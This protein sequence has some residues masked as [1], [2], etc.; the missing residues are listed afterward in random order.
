MNYCVTVFGCKKY[1]DVAH[2]FVKETISLNEE[3]ISSSVFFSDGFIPDLKMN[4]LVIDNNISW[5]ARVAKSLETVEQDYILFLLDDYFLLKKLDSEKIEMLVNWSSKLDINYC[6]LVNI[7]KDNRFGNMM[8]LPVNPYSI[9]LQPAIW[10]RKLL[11]S[12]LNH[13][14][15]NPWVTETSLPN[16]FVNEQNFYKSAVGFNLIDGYLNAV[17]KGKWSRKVPNLLFKDSNRPK[18]N[19][20][21]WFYYRTKSILSDSLS[22]YLKSILKNILKKI[23]FN[24][25]S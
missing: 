24:F 13:V 2:I 9:N 3:L 6:R 21:E 1:E 22:P 20:F 5:S 11:I 17:I 8:P 12:I 19:R 23:G 16:Y 7:P 4:Q 25:Y 10:N 14:D 15:S 18:M